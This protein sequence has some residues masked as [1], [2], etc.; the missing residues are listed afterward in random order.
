MSTS[1]T[2][3]AS[4]LIEI[5]TPPKRSPP[6]VKPVNGTSAHRPLHKASEGKEVTLKARIITAGHVSSVIQ[7]GPTH[8]RIGNA[9]L[10]DL[11]N[12]PDL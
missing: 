11:T 3:F 6:M 5:I 8:V 9:A 4:V 2:A 1:A 7:I 12:Q 10:R